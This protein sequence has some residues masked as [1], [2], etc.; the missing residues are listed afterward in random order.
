MFDRLLEF[1]KELPGNGFRDRKGDISN[2]DPKLAAAAL[3]FHIMDV[4]GETRESE[5]KKRCTEEANQGR[6][7]GR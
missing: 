1:L 4:D 6:R 7:S 3:L 5:R 2:D